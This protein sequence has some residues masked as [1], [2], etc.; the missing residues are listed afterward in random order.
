MT[1]E[2]F[3]SALSKVSIREKN[4]DMGRGLQQQRPQSPSPA[5]FYRHRHFPRRGAD[6][7]VPIEIPA[8][9]PEIERLET[10]KNNDSVSVGPKGS[11]WNRYR[12]NTGEHTRC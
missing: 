12:I 4:R 8:G 1:Y 9:F 11:T 5:T 10:P 7:K 3:L 2:Q 6:R